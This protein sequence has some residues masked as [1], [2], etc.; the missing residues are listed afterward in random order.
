MALQFDTST[1]DNITTQIS[2]NLEN[3]SEDLSPGGLIQ[4]C[5]IQVTVLQKKSEE[6]YCDPSLNFSLAQLHNTD[7]LLGATA[8]WRT[9][10]DRQQ[11]YNASTN[12][13]RS[14]VEGAKVYFDLCLGGEAL[15]DLAYSGQNMQAKYEGS[16]LADLHGQDLVFRPYPEN[17]N[18]TIT[19]PS[20]VLVQALSAEDKDILRVA[21]ASLYLPN[22][23]AERF[24]VAYLDHGG[25]P[26]GPPSVGEYIQATMMEFQVLGA[27]IQDLPPDRLIEISFMVPPS[28]NVRRLDDVTV[29]QSESINYI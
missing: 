3:A 1:S 20:E 21:G 18:V 16:P 29:L 10:S 4:L 2:Q 28:Q 13:L 27:N 14:I 25:P 23:E 5:S 9:I 19:V 8:A 7:I 11:A 26:S 22:H 6:N 15:G 12:L 24:P 17:G